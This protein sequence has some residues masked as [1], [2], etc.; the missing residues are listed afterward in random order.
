MDD[1]TARREHSGDIRFYFPVVAHAITETFAIFVLRLA[2]QK[3]IRVVDDQIFA[4]ITSV[5]RTTEYVEQRG[6]SFK[7]I[8]A[9]THGIRK[10]DGS[11]ERRTARENKHVVADSPTD[12][13]GDLLT[14]VSANVA[15][16]QFR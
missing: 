1:R 13:F 6:V 9:G 16:G 11:H 7:N 5:E 8:H 10:P 12:N 2:Q 3:T 14:F 15:C 4:E